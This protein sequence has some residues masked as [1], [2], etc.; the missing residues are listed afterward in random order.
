MAKSKG[1]AQAKRKLE[2]VERKITKI[3]GTVAGGKRKSY[4]IPLPKFSFTTGGFKDI[5]SFSKEFPK[6]FKKA[7]AKTMELLAADLKRALDDAMESSTWDWINDTRD[8]ID[9]GALRDSGTVTYIPA[10]E[11]LSIS[12]DQDYAAIVHFGGY[13]RSGYNPSVQ[14]YYPARPWI[15]AVLEGGYAVEQ[16]EFEKRYLDYFLDILAKETS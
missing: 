4:S 7:H 1:F 9:T 15:T 10:Q 3:T 14:I 6:A 13:I 12:Y 16:F 5:L 8:I 2:Q 11:S